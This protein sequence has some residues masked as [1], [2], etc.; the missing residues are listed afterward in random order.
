MLRLDDAGTRFA[1][2]LSTRY[3]E[4]RKDGD[5]WRLKT[6]DNLEYVFTH[7]PG[8]ASDAPWLLTEVRDLIGTDRVVIEYDTVGIGTCAPDLHPRRLSYGWSAAGVPLYQ[9]ELGYEAWWRPLGE[10]SGP[11]CATRTAGGVVEKA[12]VFDHGTDP[13]LNSDSSTQPRS[14]ILTS[15]TILARNNLDASSSPRTVKRYQLAYQPDRT[16]AKP[17][18]TAVTQ[19]GE[20]GGGTLPVAMYYYG[21]LQ[22]V[23]LSPGRAGVNWTVPIAVPRSPALPAAYLDDVSE[24]AQSESSDGESHTDTTKLRHTIR[25]FTGDGVPDELW[26]DGNTWHLAR[27]IVTAAG[28]RLDGPESTWTQ[29]AEIDWQNTFRYTDVDDDSGHLNHGIATEAWTQFVDWNGDGRLDV[30]ETRGGSAFRMW[31][32][33]INQDDGVGG[34][35]WRSTEVDMGV[36]REYLHDRGMRGYDAPTPVARRI[37]APRNSTYYCHETVCNCALGECNFGDGFEGVKRH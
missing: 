1:P 8:A 20:N 32:I 27:G 2:F 26:K 28:P 24:A 16:T 9:V 33:W 7:Q 17:R 21:A 14:S 3:Q 4:L 13:L 5:T 37:S 30:I 31:K 10:S 15:V 35:Q 36:F 6:L 29:P 18:L 12:V 23:E 34:V 22:T 25:D 19:Q 11:T